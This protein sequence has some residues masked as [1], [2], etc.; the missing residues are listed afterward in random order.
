MNIFL[1]III[2]VYNVEAYLENCLFSILNQEFK[3][4]EIILIDDGSTDNSGKICD[5]YASKYENIVVVHQSNLGVSSARNKGLFLARGKYIHFVDSDDTIDADTYIKNIPILQAN[6]NIDFLSFP[7]NFHR[8]GLVERKYVHSAVYKGSHE[9]FMYYFNGR[10]LKSMDVFL[11]HKIFRKTVFCNIFFPV[12]KICEDVFII[13]LICQNSQYAVCTP[14]G[15]YNYYKR[16]GSLLDL[17]TGMFRTQYIL[18]TVESTLNCLCYAKEIKQL[19]RSRISSYIGL[20][21]LFE[22]SLLKENSERKSKIEQ[23]LYTEMPSIKDLIFYSYKSD[24]FIII[25]ILL[26][27]VLGFKYALRLFNLLTGNNGRA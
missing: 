6:S 3:D 10:K 12:G 22:K 2:P 14:Y 26:A 16:Q 25:F 20:V 24:K 4:Y 15:G 27:K 8:R 7:I 23:R 5:N 18:D 9:I 13:P 1:S 21:L 17:S 19:N 11:W